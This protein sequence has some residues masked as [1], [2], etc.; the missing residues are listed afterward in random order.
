LKQPKRSI[1][2]SNTGKEVTKKMLNNTVD[3]ARAWKDAEYRASLSADQLSNLPTSPINNSEDELDSNLVIGGQAPFSSQG[4]ICS[5]S[6]EC[7]GG[8]C[9]NPFT[10]LASAN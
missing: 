3:V 10:S 7:N 9:C 4:W 5:I 6:G 2:K 8:H 1:A